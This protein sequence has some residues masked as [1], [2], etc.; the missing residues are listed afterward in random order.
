MIAIDLA[1]R[2]VH[3]T[4]R[5]SKKTISNISC[6]AITVNS[7]HSSQ[8]DGGTVELQWQCSEAEPLRTGLPTAEVH[9]K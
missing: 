7:C 8:A 9:Y 5:S 1:V 6:P 2:R 3:A 4:T